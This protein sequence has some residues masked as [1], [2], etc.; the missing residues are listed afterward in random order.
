MES[1]KGPSR[2]ISILLIES[3][4]S[5]PA[6][7]TFHNFPHPALVCL[8]T[9]FIG[10]IIP[11]TLYP[12][13][14]DFPWFHHSDLG[15]L[16]NRVYYLIKLVNINQKISLL[17]KKKDIYRPSVSPIKINPESSSVYKQKKVKESAR[18]L[19]YIGSKYIRLSLTQSG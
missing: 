9:S 8:G 15:R 7:D 14:C 2:S 19:K 12:N 5:I 16:K 18:Y 3:V 13:C 17:I 6:P 1:V 11:L 4:G 10:H